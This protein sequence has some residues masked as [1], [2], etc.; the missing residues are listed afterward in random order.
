MRVLYEHTQAATLIY[1]ILAAMAFLFIAAG[2]VAEDTPLWFWLFTLG[3]IGLI[4]VL[5]G[6][7]HVRVT[8]EAVEFKYGVGLVKKRIELTTVRRAYAASDPWYWGWGIRWTPKG[9]LYR[10]SGLEC[11]ALEIEGKDRQVRIGTDDATG[12]ARALRDA[13]PEILGEA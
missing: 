3:F 11:V 4:L 7:L 9:W 13:L 10:V 1:V 8:T 5:F 6:S 12:L 2:M